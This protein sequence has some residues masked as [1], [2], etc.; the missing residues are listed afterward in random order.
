MKT[1]TGVLKR[2]GPG[3]GQVHQTQQ[4]ITHS[5]RIAGG[6]TT[7]SLIR[8]L[9]DI[10]DERIPK[11]KLTYYQDSLLEEAVGHEVTLVLTKSNGLFSLRTPAGTVKQSRGGVIARLVFQTLVLGVG[12]LFMG[13]VV[14]L[15]G[16]AF[17][18]GLL[19]VVFFVVVSIVVPIFNILE[20]VRCWGALG[21]SA[22]AALVPNDQQQNPGW[23]PPVAGT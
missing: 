21:G 2:M 18:L 15:L 17:G 4:H 16:A 14:G 1:Y 5:G 9:V 19:G 11:I 6:R 23:A 20:T 22:S 8:T 10:G 13:L 7:V 3:I 12:G